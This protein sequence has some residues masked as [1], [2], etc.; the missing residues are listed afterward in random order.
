M[1]GVAC[2]SIEARALAFSAMWW[3]GGHGEWERRDKSTDAHCSCAPIEDFGV[4]RQNGVLHEVPLEARRAGAIGLAPRCVPA[5][6]TGPD[7][8]TPNDVGRLF[9]ST[10]RLACHSPL[11]ARHGPLPACPHP[12]LLRSDAAALALARGSREADEI[13]VARP[14]EKRRPALVPGLYSRFA[15]GILATAPTDPIGGT[16]TPAAT[17]RTF[18]TRRGCGARTST[19]LSR[20][21]VEQT[22][23]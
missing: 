12:A 20:A 13:A 19:T 23:T 18:A 17:A 9:D 22:T 6:G 3:L 2:G 11:G 16:T 8:I 4:N 14:G 21:L 15:V 7:R 5:G 10:V 1:A